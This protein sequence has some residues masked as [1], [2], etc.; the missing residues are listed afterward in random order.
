MC[1]CAGGVAALK[2]LCGGGLQ[3]RAGIS[4]NAPRTSECPEANV[5]GGAAVNS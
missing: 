2:K 3:P 4:K 1:V 5:V